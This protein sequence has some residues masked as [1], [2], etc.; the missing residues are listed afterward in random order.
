M[1]SPKRLTARAAEREPD[2]DLPVPLGDADKWPDPVDA[3]RR[4]QERDHGKARGEQHGNPAGQQ[5]LVEQRV[6]RLDAVEGEGRVEARDHAANRRHGRGFVDRGLHDQA[7]AALRRLG[8]GQVDAAD[9][10]RGR[11]HAVKLHFTR[12]TFQLT[13]IHFVSGPVSKSLSALP[14]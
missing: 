8:E 5:R 10:D 7:K 9:R 14:G 1:M 3:D 12:A 11:R 6:H 2:A 13:V 4:E